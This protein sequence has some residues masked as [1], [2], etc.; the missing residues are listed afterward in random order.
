MS[1]QPHVHVQANAFVQERGAGVMAFHPGSLRPGTQQRLQAGAPFAISVQSG[2]ADP[3]Y[4]RQDVLALQA[5]F[6]ACLP[7][8]AFP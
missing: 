5:R 3:S 2:Y 7:F 1:V 6:V 8:T 4:S